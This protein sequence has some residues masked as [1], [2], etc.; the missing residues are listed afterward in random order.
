MTS[1]L[2]IEVRHL[3]WSDDCQEVKEDNLFSEF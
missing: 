3:R 2:H 1:L